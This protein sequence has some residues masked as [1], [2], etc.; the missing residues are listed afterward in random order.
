MNINKDQITIPNRFESILSA[1]Q[2]KEKVN[3]LILPVNDDLN[4]L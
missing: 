4:F 2:F 3:S 1:P